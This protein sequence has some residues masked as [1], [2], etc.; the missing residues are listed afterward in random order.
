TMSHPHLSESKSYV[1]NCVSPDA[2]KIKNQSNSIMKTRRIRAAYLP[3]N[4][5]Q[6]RGQPCPRELKS[7]NSRTKLSALRSVAGPWSRSSILGS[8]RLSLSRIHAVE[9]QTTGNRDFG[10]SR[11]N[12]LL[13][14]TNLTAK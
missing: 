11:S 12:S 9:Q 7:R 1:G 8:W 3:L 10:A 13:W 6:E 4:R 5:C 14:R 2:G